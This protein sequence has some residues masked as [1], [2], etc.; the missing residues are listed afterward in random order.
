MEQAQIAAEPKE[1]SAWVKIIARIAKRERLTKRQAE[2]ILIEFAE[3]LE[4]ELFH[5]ER[6]AIPRLG[7]FRIRRMKARRIR[8]P[9]T[10]EPMKLKA[11]RS[12]GFRPAKSFKEH[13]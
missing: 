8:N 6:V 10:G 9:V 13:L 5:R 7:V 3:E 1:T 4:H 2:R 11:R 12:V